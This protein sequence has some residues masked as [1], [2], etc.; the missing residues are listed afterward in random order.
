MI[1]KGLRT[2]LEENPIALTKNH[3]Y[4]SI[5]LVPKP[6]DI[7][8]KFTTLGCDRTSRIGGATTQV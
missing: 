4:K 3:F 5:I 6:L 1:L 7:I 8:P 2:G